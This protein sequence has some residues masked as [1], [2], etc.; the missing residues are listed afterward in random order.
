M[1]TAFLI[2]RYL[3]SSRVVWFG[4]LA[5]A[6]AVALLIVVTSLFEGFISAFEANRR[7]QQGDILMTFWTPLEDP[8]RLVTA[9]EDVHGVASATVM[10]TQPGL[11]YR[12]R[13]DVR[14]VLLTGCY[15][16]PWQASQE[17]S[18]DL[19]LP[20][21]KSFTLPTGLRQAMTAWAAGRFGDA[22]ATEHLPVPAVLGAGLMCPE[23]D[24]TCDK[25]TIA[26]EIADQTRP[27]IV[28]TAPL[29]TAGGTPPSVVQMP[30][31]AVNVLHHHNDF[32]DQRTVY[33]PL[34]RID[35]TGTYF[36]RFTLDPSVQH[37]PEVV[38]AALGATWQQLVHDMGLP[39]IA[40]SRYYVEYP[41]LA[42]DRLT[43]AI[44][45][46]LRIMQML[47]GLIA[48]VGS[49]LIFVILLM[50]VM[51]KRRDMGILHAVG[52]GH[53]A[54][55]RLFLCFAM[56]IGAIGSAGGVVLG[57]LATRYIN[58][59]EA[60][61]SD[62]LGFKIWKA[63]VY[64]FDRI[65]DTVAWGSVGWIVVVGIAAAALGAVVPAVRA[66]RI[67][68]AACLNYE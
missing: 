19:V 64:L 39:D 20:D 1:T 41:L 58:V 2:L 59:L 50:L 4:A 32:Q 67:S 11:L 23:Q 52:V 5:V 44:R 8:C 14:M 62:V 25:T 51:R 37:N 16:V 48:L 45:K 13:G 31:A 10:R 34:D 24:E 42:T 43:L 68:A 3:R 29:F 26:N 17:T 53:W 6:M 12:G 55:A 49:A 65:P 63:S 27:M 30:V 22:Q 7:A 15:P 38:T 66:A 33:L 36:M 61:L 47:V 9:F 18:A 40:A 54:T 57:A 35:T 60:A 21:I 46:Q 28:L 56:L